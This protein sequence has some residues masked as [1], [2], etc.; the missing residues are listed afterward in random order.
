M[1]GGRRRWPLLADRVLAG[2]A[3][4][5]LTLLGVMGLKGAVGPSSAL[6]PAPFATLAFR[7]YCRRRFLRAFEDAPLE[8]AAAADAAAAS[9]GGGGGGVFPYER[10]TMV[11]GDL[12][13][14]DEGAVALAFLA[15]EEVADDAA[16]G[17]GDHHERERLASI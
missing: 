1:S 10:P 15:S 7:C 14:E 13:P 16:G 3:I 17:R 6:L 12:V 11:P 8:A 4:A 2:L 9:A 5:Q